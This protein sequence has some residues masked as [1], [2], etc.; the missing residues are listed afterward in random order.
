M[1]RA[2]RSHGS[3]SKGW[4]WGQ[5]QSKPAMVGWVERKRLH[6]GSAEGFADND[7]MMDV[8]SAGE[9]EAE[10]KRCDKVGRMDEDCSTRSSGEF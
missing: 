7:A 10:G 3:A 2:E 8:E 9:M 6:V 1:S 4:V 5:N